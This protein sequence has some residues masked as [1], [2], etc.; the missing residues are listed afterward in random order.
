MSMNETKIKR[1]NGAV[2][3]TDNEGLKAYKKA[4]LSS[5]VMNNR[6]TNLEEKIDEIYSLLL[7]LNNKGT[8]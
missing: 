1:M 5:Q 6:I 8:S 3:S 2:I 7:Q 4:K